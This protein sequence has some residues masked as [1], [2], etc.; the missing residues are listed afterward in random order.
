MLQIQLDFSV[1]S[2]HGKMGQARTPFELKS[3]DSD[4]GLFHVQMPL[5]FGGDDRVVNRFWEA[6]CLTSRTFDGKNAVRFRLVEIV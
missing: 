4:H 2:L 3:Y 1:A 6:L 5:V